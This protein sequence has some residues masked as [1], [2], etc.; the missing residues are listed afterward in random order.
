VKA[1]SY[2]ASNRA[3]DAGYIR[4]I[5]GRRCRF[6]KWEPCDFDL[7]K[8]VSAME[9]KEQMALVVDRAIQSAREEKQ[10]VPKSGVRRAF[11]YR[12]MNRLIQGS[13]ADMTKKALVEVFRAGYLPHIQVHDELDT[14]VSCQE[15]V[16]KISAIMRD[17]VPLCVPVRV[18]AEVGE[19]WGALSGSFKW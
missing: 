18:D 14:S 5:L 19:N 12:A 3:A 13:A 15:D 1:L 11:T 7:A 17:A 10:P 8:K 9:D 2:A 16:Q 6:N 4:T